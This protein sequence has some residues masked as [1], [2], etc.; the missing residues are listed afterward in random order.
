MEGSFGVLASVGDFR[1]S[2]R[3]LLELCPPRFN[4]AVVHFAILYSRL[5][6]IKSHLKIEFYSHRSMKTAV[7]EHQCVEGKNRVSLCVLFPPQS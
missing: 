2:G 4:N 7:L 1:G 3:K 5:C 6:R